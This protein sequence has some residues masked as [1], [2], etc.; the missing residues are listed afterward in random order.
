ALRLRPVGHEYHDFSLNSLGG[1][2]VTHFNDIDDITQAI[3][4][5]CE[6]LTLHSPGYP[7]RDTVL[8]NLALVFKIR[9]KKLHVIEDLNEAIDW[10]RESLRLLWHDHPE[11]HRA[12]H[13]LSSALCSCFMHTRKNEDVK[14]AI[15]LCREALTILPSLHPDR[16]FSYMW[17]QK[18]YLS[19]YQVQLSPPDLSL[20]I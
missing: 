20:A 12:L 4:L 16:C 10:Y 2:L 18:A 3:S 11:R 6:A 13:N 14:E 8:N 19:R 1:A 9:Y 17:L 15:Q 7:Y 5:Y